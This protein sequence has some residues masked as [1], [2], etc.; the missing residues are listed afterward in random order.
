MC[1]IPAQVVESWTT[2]K[3]GHQCSFFAKLNY[4]LLGYY[5]PIIKKN[6]VEKKQIFGVTSALSRQKRQNAA[7]HE[8]ESNTAVPVVLFYPKHRLDHPEK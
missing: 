5:D 4:F 1:N 8:H 2:P 3:A 6:H 7:G